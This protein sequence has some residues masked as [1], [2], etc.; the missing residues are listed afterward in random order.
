MAIIAAPNGID[1]VT[2]KS[3]EL[4]ILAMKLQVN[5]VYGEA[6]L[7][8]LALDRIRTVVAICI[9]LPLCQEQQRRESNEC[10][11]RLSQMLH[12]SS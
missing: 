3:N 1:Q 2:A 11:K 9:S 7:N 8:A 4:A 12:G 10:E 6:K 5:G